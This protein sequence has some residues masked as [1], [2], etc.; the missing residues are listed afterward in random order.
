MTNKIQQ[1]KSIVK[2]LELLIEQKLK[3]LQITIEMI[4]GPLGLQMGKKY[5]LIKV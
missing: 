5:C 2:G 1:H 4:R 3:N